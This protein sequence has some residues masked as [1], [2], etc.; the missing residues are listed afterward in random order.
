[1]E[2]GKVY[3]EEILA[4]TFKMDIGGKELIIKKL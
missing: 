4:A 1:L 3:P 2:L